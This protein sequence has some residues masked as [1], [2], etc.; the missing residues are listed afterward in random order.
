MGG[1]TGQ[2]VYAVPVIRALTSFPLKVST[3][4]AAC[5]KIC[6]LTVVGAVATSVVPLTHNKWLV[7]FSAKYNPNDGI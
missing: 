7:V 2:N 3:P 5:R 4:E 6:P 1:F